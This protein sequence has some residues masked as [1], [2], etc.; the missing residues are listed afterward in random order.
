MVDQLGENSLVIGTIVAA[1]VPADALRDPDRDDA[2]VIAA[3]PPLAFLA[4]DH[5]AA[6]SSGHHFPFHAGWRR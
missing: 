5:F 4:P 1:R 3:A 2:D 6:V